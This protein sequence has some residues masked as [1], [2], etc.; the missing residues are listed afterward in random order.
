MPSLYIYLIIAFGLGAL[1]AWLLTRNHLSNQ[2]TAKTTSFDHL[3]KQNEEIKADSGRIKTKSD[4]LENEKKKLETSF[5]ITSGNL[6]TSKQTLSDKQEEIKNL[7][8]INKTQNEQYLK[9]CKE[10]STLTA[11]QK[12]LDEKLENQ[13]REMEDLQKKFSKDFELI[14]N[15]IFEDK[16][17]KFTDLNK[18]NLSTLLSPLGLDIKN[19]KSKVEEVYDKE[20]KERFSLGKE[21]EKLVLANLKISQEA[22]NLT[23]ALTA[24]GKTQGDWGQMI[25]ESIL[26]QSGLIKDTQ[27]F[28]QEY[29]KDEEGNYLVNDQGQRLQ[30]DVVVVFPDNRKIIIDA[31]VSLT[32]YNHYT[33]TLDKE[34][35]A[36]YFSDHIRSVKKHIDDLSA[37]T[38][39]DFVPTMDFVMMFIPIE[40]AFLM[41]IH[42]D[43][44]LWSYA[45]NKRIILTSPS[46]L[47]LALKM[48]LDHWKRDSQNKNH[49]EIA[50]R[51]GKLYDKFVGVLNSLKDV[52]KHIKNT[53]LSYNNAVSQLS[54]GND[55]VLKQVEKLKTLGAKA[56]SSLP[57]IDV[58]KIGEPEGGETEE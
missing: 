12:Y 11:N 16:S 47:I 51:G 45:Y 57:N 2:L 43:R 31:K 33:A 40:P 38:Y 24:K 44:D 7:Q 52:G 18:E 23:N 6:E 32:A 10:I 15:K 34:E 17:K 37:K 14:A 27:Y 20:S 3:L 39:Q 55:N 28:V 26:E 5:G 50:E 58:I 35:E 1:L 13:E 54:E 56:K 42:H 9:D 25:L 46:N 19:F 48:I 22:N 8:A 49:M 36:R 4:T 41:A 29:L 53:H 21:V 30:P